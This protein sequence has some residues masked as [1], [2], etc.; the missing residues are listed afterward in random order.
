MRRALLGVRFCWATLR[1]PWAL[2]P[3]TQFDAV[4]HPLLIL[5]ALIVPCEL[6]ADEP[7]AA[8]QNADDRDQHRGQRDWVDAGSVLFLQ[9][10]LLSLGDAAFDARQDVT[11]ALHLCLKL[12]DGGLDAT[13]LTLDMRQ[14][15][16]MIY[17]HC[18]PQQR[19][20][21]EDYATTLS[22]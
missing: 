20:P 14:P 6:A 18:A 3:L 17:C 21:C 11:K 9:R 12:S 5:A 2:L 19:G 15:R 22:R 10:L 7:C 8:D 16:A 4:D 13:D 1:F